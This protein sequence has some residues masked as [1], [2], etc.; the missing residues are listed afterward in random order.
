MAETRTTPGKVEVAGGGFVQKV[1][2]GNDDL[3]VVNAARVS[4]AKQVDTFDEERD[5]SLLHYLYS[6]RHWT[7]FAHARMGVIVEDTD[8][9]AWKIA[10]ADW[11]LRN[12]TE[13]WEFSLVGTSLH[14]E[15]SLWNWVGSKELP[16]PW[17]ARSSDHV[18]YQRLFCNI[19]DRFPHSSRFV[20][21]AYGQ[22]GPYPTFTTRYET[23]RLR[24]PIFVARQW[25]RSNVGIVYNETSRRYVNDRPEFWAT[26]AEGYRGAPKD[27]KKQGSSTE[28]VRVFSSEA[29]RQVMVD[30]K[31]NWPLGVDLVTTA[32]DFNE[33]AEFLYV[34]MLLAG[35]CPEQARTVL[36]QSMHTDLWMT[37]S[38]DAI[39]R[40]LFLRDGGDG[41]PQVEIQE[42][43]QALKEARNG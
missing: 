36:P 11:S 27:G 21:T 32:A 38:P 23:Y 37:A 13:G 8:V 40:I 22:V 7:P 2:H 34:Q 6:H 14:V 35:A 4:F 15:G 42:M 24:M 5:K 30:Q 12:R 33:T 3:T 9:D 31:E 43:A 20:P 18:P 10:Y 16:P 25:M 41:H 1:E 39:D 28:R 19:I 26:D 29:M 17:D